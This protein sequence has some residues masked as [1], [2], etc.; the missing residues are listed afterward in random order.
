[1]EMLYNE[2]N[3]LKVDEEVQEQYITHSAYVAHRDNYRPS[4]G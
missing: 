3:K 4:P 1:M 2:E